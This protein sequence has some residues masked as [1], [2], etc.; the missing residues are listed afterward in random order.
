MLNALLNAYT[1]RLHCTWHRWSI[2][3]LSSSLSIHAVKAWWTLPWSIQPGQDE[4]EYMHCIITWLHLLTMTRSI[5]LLKQFL[6]FWIWQNLARWS[7]F[8]FLWMFFFS[9]SFSNTTTF[10]AR[11]AWYD[12]KGKGALLK[13]LKTVFIPS[14]LTKT[15]FIPSVL[16]MWG[17]LYAAKGVENGVAFA[18]FC[19][20]CLFFN[21]FHL[22]LRVFPRRYT[23]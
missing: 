19:S 11:D 23:L 18:N 10:S 14:V 22:P 20:R 16:T 4:D 9:N 15:V 21:L 13:G 2:Q 3:R 17:I 8:I 5:Q 12:V 7:R 6:E 1:S